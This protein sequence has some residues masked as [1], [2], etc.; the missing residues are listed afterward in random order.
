MILNFVNSYKNCVY[1]EKIKIY[2]LIKIQFDRSAF[3]KI[4]LTYT[5]ILHN[6][7]LNIKTKL[8]LNV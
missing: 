4:I 3:N 5:F 1:L 2:E 7:I 8:M 6:I